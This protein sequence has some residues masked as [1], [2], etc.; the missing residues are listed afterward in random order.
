[1]KKQILKACAF[2]VTSLLV[3]E[4]S[5][6][7]AFIPATGVSP[8]DL[9]TDGGTQN[10]GIHDNSPVFP[11]T[12]NG[13]IGYTQSEFDRYLKGNSTTALGIYS[14][15]DWVDGSGIA[16]SSTDGIDFASASVGVGKAFTFWS[17]SFADPLMEIKNDAK[18][19]F[20]GDLYFASSGLDRH[21]HGNTATTFALYSATGWNDGSG[22]A[23]ASPANG[24]GIDFVATG[25]GPD[26]AF[27]YWSDSYT[28]PL[29]EIKK[30]AKIDFYGDLSFASSGYN[31]HIS[32]NTSTVMALY[33]ATGWK[34]GAGIMLSAINSSVNPGG[35]TLVSNQ[36]AG[37]GT[38]FDFQLAQNSDGAWVSRLMHI[39]KDGQV[40]I[41][42]VPTVDANTYRLYVE[43]GILTEKVKVALSDD[44]TNWSDFVFEDDY[45][46]KSLDE[47]ESYIKD[48]K[49]LPEIPSTEEVHANGLDLAQMDAKLL[50]KIEELTLYMIQ[51]QKEINKLKSQLNK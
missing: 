31:R 26:K 2:A 13:T 47:V 1:M 20:Y 22:I 21:F 41:G 38:A 51:Q 19:D 50:Q 32:G 9:V 16:L 49:H 46:L 18:I 6:G 33:S 45:E 15:T 36:G 42:D 4:A 11:L 39:E 10:V 43:K 8:D 48:N 17:Q 7:Q 25:T 35:V 34:D 14:G 28:K 40:V 27:T 23:L 44:Q 29:M 30:N 12:V 5:Y 24:G 3:S 37:T